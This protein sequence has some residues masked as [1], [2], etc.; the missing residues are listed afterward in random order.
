MK[1]TNVLAL[2]AAVSLAQAASSDHWA[3]IVAGSNGFYNY[4]HQ[5]DACHAYHIM[6][7]NGIPEEQIILMAYDDVANNSQ[8]PFPGKLFNKPDG[9][10][11]YG[12]CNIDYKGAEVNKKNFIAVLEG[13]AQK[14]GGKV[15]AGDANSKVFVNFIDHGAPGLVCFP[16]EYMYA[17][18]LNTAL[19][20]S[21]ANGLFGEM[22]FY[23]EAC[24]SGSMFDNDQ[25]AED[26]SVYALSA[27]NASSS[28]WGTYCYPSDMVNG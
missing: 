15:L 21:K 14:A 24:E 19:K 9:N 13:D 1:F 10:D 2:G 6:K 25:L 3:V 20:T 12:G 7:D 18:E 8:N 23:L 26:S 22:V 4:R 11:V 5:A 17:D 16:S 28:S 27:T